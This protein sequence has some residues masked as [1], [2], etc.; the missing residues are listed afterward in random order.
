MLIYTIDG[1]IGSG[2]S[3]I[4]NYL[5]K[6][7]NLQIDLEPLEKWKSFL[8]NIYLYKTGFFNFQIKVWL[9]R[10]WIQEKESNSIILM[11]R[12]PFFIRNTFTINDYNNNN[13]NEEEYKVI[14]E[15]YN[16]TDTIWKSN[17]Y[18]YLRSSP[19]KCLER[20]KKR[21]RENEINTITIDYL[22]DIHLLHEEAYNKALEKK[23]NIL[24][25]DVDNKDT[26]EIIDE[27]ISFIS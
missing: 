16:K 24:I 26:K 20:I 5:H 15:L 13:I 7:K 3:T 11:E 9:D 25:I 1:N 8:D 23:Y 27:I 6:Y 12:S 4:L 22:T 18:I 14:N 17:N 21:G 2:K 10:A 19:T